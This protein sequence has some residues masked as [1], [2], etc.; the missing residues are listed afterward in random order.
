MK[1]FTI[2]SFL[3]V[4]GLGYIPFGPG[5]FG[6]LGGLVFWYFTN[7]VSTMYYIVMT[8]IIIVVSCYLS[9]FS[10]ELYGQKDSQRIV[11]DEFCGYLVTMIGVPF[12]LD[13][14]WWTP[15]LGFVLFRFFDIVK[16]VPVNIM[17]KLP[18]GLGVV[19]DDVMAGLYSVIIIHVILQIM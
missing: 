19:A 5:T 3:S 7:G 13:N 11:L 18:K 16:P 10:E 15:I 6:T 8:I 12:A 14:L 2:K 17:E 9:S 1:N 4:F